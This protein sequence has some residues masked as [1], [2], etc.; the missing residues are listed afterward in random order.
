MTFEF[1]LT[2]ILKLLAAFLLALPVAI[3]REKHSRV[4]GL[5]TYPLM[6]M[7]ACAYMLIGT[8]FIGDLSVDAQARIIQGLL[9]GLGFLGAGAIIQNND[10][11]EGTASAVCI[12]I[13]GAVGLACAHGQW[14]IAV[15]LSLTAWLVL[16]LFFVWKKELEGKNLESLPEEDDDD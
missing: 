3:N 12:W 13:F 4:M 11:V 5:R 16:N 14:L 1:E 6:S 8:G 9:G 2:V 10:R 15:V 7:G